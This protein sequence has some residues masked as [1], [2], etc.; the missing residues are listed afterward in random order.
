MAVDQVRV[1]R[2][3]VDADGC[4]AV[5]ADLKGGREPEVSGNGRQA[6]PLC[7]SLHDT[8]QLGLAGAQSNGLLSRGPMPDGVQPAHAHSPA[9][10]PQ[11]QQTPGEDRLN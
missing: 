3:R 7:R 2:L 5:C 11:S 8:C 4:A 1:H 9:R 10:G 6:Q